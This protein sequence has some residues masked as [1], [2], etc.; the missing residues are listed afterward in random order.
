L[1][2]NVPDATVLVE[3]AH[4]DRAELGLQGA[5][6]V[7]YR[8]PEEHRFRAVDFGMQLPGCRTES[9]VKTGKFGPRTRL[10][11]EL[12][13]DF[14]QAGRVS[15]AFVLDPELEAPRRADP[16]DRRRRDWDKKARINRPRFAGYVLQHSIGALFAGALL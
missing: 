11:Q 6:H 5:V 14:I 10:C 8:H 16:R 1:K 7:R 15:G 12:L 4:L 3:L 2:N 13:G 9:S